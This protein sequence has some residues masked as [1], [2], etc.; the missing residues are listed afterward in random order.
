MCETNLI[1]TREEAH[2][3]ARLAL[4]YLNRHGVTPPT[5]VRGK[6]AEGGLVKKEGAD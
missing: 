6:Y 1:I 2:E 5:I 4:E 3:R